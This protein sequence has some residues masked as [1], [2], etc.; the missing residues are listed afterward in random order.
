MED[1]LIIYIIL[2]LPFLFFVTEGSIIIMA[3]TNQMID[4]LRVEG[5]MAQGYG[6]NPKIVMRDKRLTPEAKCIYSYLASFAGGGNQ[7]FPSRDIML[8][9]LQ[10]SKDRYYRHLK[11]LVDADYV[12]ISRTK[13][14]G[15]FDKNTY[16]L[17]A[18]PNPVT[19]EES[20]PVKKINQISDQAAGIKSAGNQK[21][22]KR[23]QKRASVNE[24]RERLDIENLKLCDNQN[25][26]LIEDVFM[27]IEDIN[28]SEQ[29]SISGTIKKRDAIEEIIAQLTSDHVRLVVDAVN[30]YKK[31]LTNRKAY[32]QTCVV[33]SIFNIR[34][35]NT[36]TQKALSETSAVLAE[37]A[38]KEL[39]E[40]ELKEEIKEVY[41]CY[42]ELR[43]IDEELED[44]MKKLSR[45]LLQKDEITTKKLRNKI[46]ELN[47]RRNML[48]EQYGLA[49]NI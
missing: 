18:L 16:T 6:I 17:V 34:N 3:N 35:Q 29:I 4:I 20:V 30:N 25:A 37:E 44:Q 19:K 38:K 26:N 31:P 9:E 28:A 7:A 23:L 39:A 12:R 14:K 27:A 21:R 45:V 46:E 48:K 24:L 42:P 8:D 10:M 32:I 47:H 13:Q 5:I 15:A 22:T 49:S 2:D 41:K 43:L 40:K 1:L 33:N 11:F 36:E